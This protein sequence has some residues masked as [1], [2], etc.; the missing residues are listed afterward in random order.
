[1]KELKITFI[2][3]SNQT[4]TKNDLSY[5]VIDEKTRIIYIVYPKTI[6]RIPFENVKMIEET[7]GEDDG[8]KTK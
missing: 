6:V 1:M 4:F 2:D 5:F 7:R 8:A 3:G